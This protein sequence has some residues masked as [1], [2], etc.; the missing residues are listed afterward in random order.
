MANNINNTNS[1][2][3]K[4]LVPRFIS[5]NTIRMCKQQLQKNNLTLSTNKIHG[6]KN[7]NKNKKE[8]VTT[9]T[10]DIT[11]NNNSNNK[12]KKNT[13]VIS[14]FTLL[15]IEILH[16]IFTHLDNLSLYQ[17]TL[18]SSAIRYQLQSY[19]S[20]LWRNFLVD[21]SLLLYDATVFLSMFI[22]F[23]S[24]STSPSYHLF[25]H[26]SMSLFGPCLIKYYYSCFSLFKLSF[27]KTRYSN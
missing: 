18:T 24:F 12:K 8:A 11:N 9:T 7:K 5:R 3:L 15:P 19:S 10:T 4:R 27:H 26:Q 22:F 23:N 25:N 1:S 2:P 13:T 14:Y 6:Y 17:L 20:T 21:P 16:H